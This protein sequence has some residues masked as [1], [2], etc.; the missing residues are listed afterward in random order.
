[1]E[2]SPDRV[3]DELSGKDVSYGN[4]ESKIVNKYAG[5]NTVSPVRTVGGGASNNFFSY[6]LFL[7]PCPLWRGR[8]ANQVTQYRIL[9][10][11][12]LLLKG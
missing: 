5:C 1:M 9:G 3:W 10:E 11:Q 12:L 4:A 6:P 7:V 8:H 2:P